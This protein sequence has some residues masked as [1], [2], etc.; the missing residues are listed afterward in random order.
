MLIIQAVDANGNVLPLSQGTTL[1][2]WTGNYSGQPGKAFAKILKDNMSG[3]T[4]TSAYWRPVTIVEDN[5]LAP[6]ATDSSSYTFT[7]PS[8]SPANVKVTLVYRRAFQLLETQKG[9]N[10]PDIKMNETTLKVEK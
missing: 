9:W 7:L 3:E 2:D 4:P 10:D 1:P 6:W 8:G 5:R